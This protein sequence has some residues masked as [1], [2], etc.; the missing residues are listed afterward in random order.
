MEWSDDDPVVLRL[1]PA[2]WYETPRVSN[3]LKPEEALQRDHIRG[4]A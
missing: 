4:L 1:E 2:A 3:G